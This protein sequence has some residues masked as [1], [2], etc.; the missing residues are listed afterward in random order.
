MIELPIECAM[1]RMT[2]RM[3]DLMTD[4][5]AAAHTCTYTCCCEVL[6]TPILCPVTGT[7][8]SN[9]VIQVQLAK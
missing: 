5:S 1:E 9:L 3:I 2:E 6:S 7:Q 8:S 4:K